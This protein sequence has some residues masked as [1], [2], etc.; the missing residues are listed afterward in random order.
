MKTAFKIA[1]S[2]LLLLFLTVLLVW[3]SGAVWAKLRP[4]KIEVPALAVLTPPDQLLMGG[5]GKVSFDLT[6][7]SGMTPGNTTI[8]CGKGTVPLGSGIWQK[9]QWRWN[10]VKWHFAADFRVL[11]SGEIP[12]GSIEFDLTSFTGKS[13]GDRCKVA[14]PEFTAVIPAGEKSGG[15]LQFAGVMTPPRRR[16]SEIFEHA[17]RY[18]YIYAAAILVLTGLIWLIIRQM[19]KRSAKR[20]LPCWE[21]A[22]AALAA[23]ENRCR[24]GE[25]LPVDGYT[26]LLD[27]LR[28]YLELRFDLPVSRQTAPEF[29]SAIAEPASPLPER[30]RLQLGTFFES[31][32]MIRFAKAPA[33]TVKLLDAAGILAG[34][35][36]ATVPVSPESGDETA[37]EVKDV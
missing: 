34:F 18:K 1:F 9:R 7:P 29:I 33:D 31:A 14:I 8:N 21:A 36:R 26:E 6:L 16:F 19:K 25:L 32:D 37:P 11:S 27:I 3:G 10:R 5:E 17:G 23:L 30:Y 22:L 13:G 2:A 15:E 35:I 28:N 20:E 12:E 4:G 24:R